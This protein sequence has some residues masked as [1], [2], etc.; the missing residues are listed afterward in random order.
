LAKLTIELLDKPGQLVGV[1]KIIADLGGNVVSV[2][3]DRMDVNMDI[4]SCF[5]E[6]ALETRNQEHVNEIKKE[7]TRQGYK[8][9]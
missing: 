7:L 3:H 4:N 2:N 6:I 1:S 9:L 5:L 8:I